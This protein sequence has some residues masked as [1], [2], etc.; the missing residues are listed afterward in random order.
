MAKMKEVVRERAMM[1]EG[2]YYKPTLRSLPRCKKHQKSKNQLQVIFKK[3]NIF[4]CYYKSNKYL[5][6]NICKRQKFK[7]RNMYISQSDH[8]KV[9]LRNN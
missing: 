5:W 3:K 9:T 8:S 7:D 2:R 6:C 1:E 4:L